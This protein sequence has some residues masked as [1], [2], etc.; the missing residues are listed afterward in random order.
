MNDPNI[1]FS[2]V[3]ISDPNISQYQLPKS[4]LSLIEKQKHIQ[5]NMILNDN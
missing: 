3:A 1:N 5:E 4:Q 2:S